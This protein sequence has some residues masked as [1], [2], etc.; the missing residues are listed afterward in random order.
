MEVV[1]RIGSSITFSGIELMLT[2]LLFPGSFI[3]K[4][5]VAFAFFQL[6]GTSPGH[7]SLPKL[8]KSGLAVMLASALMGTYCKVP[9]T[10]V[11]PQVV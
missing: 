2:G 8:I 11:C 3:L 9:G 4:I 7:H 10:G 6:S 5:G 1:S